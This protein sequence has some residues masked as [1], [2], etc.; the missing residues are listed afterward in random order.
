MAIA[1]PGSSGSG[2]T[3][4]V[5]DPQLGENVRVGEEQVTGDGYYSELV[6]LSG[7]GTTEAEQDA[8]LSGNQGWIQTAISGGANVLSSALNLGANLVG[9]GGG[10]N[11]GTQTQQPQTGEGEDNEVFAGMTTQQLLLLAGG[12]GLVYY[13]TQNS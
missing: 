5:Y 12:A 3:Y 7:G 10:G 4:T 9:A 8:A 2:P 13:M 1:G 11:G 6:D